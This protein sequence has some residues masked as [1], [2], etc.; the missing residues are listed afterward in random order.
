[1]HEIIKNF[2]RKSIVKA[3]RELSRMFGYP[4]GEDID[5][6]KRLVT[7]ARNHRLSQD[8]F[9]SMM[10]MHADEEADQKKWT[11]RNPRGQASSSG[12]PVAAVAVAEGLT[13]EEKTEVEAAHDQ[14]N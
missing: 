3:S 4:E 1:M 8:V 7:V 10:K 9:K 6:V 14:A 12:P 5:A 13:K 11:K 2:S